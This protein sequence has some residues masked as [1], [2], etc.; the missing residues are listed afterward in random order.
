MRAYVLCG[1]FG[2]RL[3]SVTT[4]Q[5]A[6]VPVQGEPFLLRVLEQLAKADVTHAV[7]CAHYQADQILAQ[8]PELAAK[9]GLR[10]DVVVVAEPLGTGGALLNA[11]E[12]MPTYERYL[13]LNADTYLESS[14]YQGMI[15]ASG[16]AIL[17]VK[18]EDRQRY[19]SLAVD[20]SNHL[21]SLLEKGAE[22]AGLINGGVYC[23]SPLAFSGWAVKPCSLEQDLL[24]DLLQR[25]SVQ[26]IPYGGRFI[27]IGTPE[28]LHFFL[29]EF[30]LD[31]QS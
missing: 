15:A 1:G 5:K 30:Y 18:V 6:L 22:G 31:N 12:E 26:V 9:S 14:A 2:T 20:A 17:G 10:L 13:L 16:Q 4:A 28:S 8:L 27:D 21:L 19:G 29:N 24:P 3:R 11:L 23:F 7:L 25:E